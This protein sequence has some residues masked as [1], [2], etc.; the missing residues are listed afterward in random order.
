M[1]IWNEIPEANVGFKKV[2]DID[3]EIN[4]SEWLCIF[5]HPVSLI[6]LSSVV[7]FLDKE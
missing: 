2:P 5:N 6:D 7:P 4:P 1:Q 3:N